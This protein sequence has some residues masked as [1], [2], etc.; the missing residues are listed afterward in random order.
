MNLMKYIALKYVWVYT[1]MPL[2]SSII[3]G[4][5][6]WAYEFLKSRVYQCDSQ[7]INKKVR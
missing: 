6:L 3:V 2:T 4:R 5:G 1:Y 7:S